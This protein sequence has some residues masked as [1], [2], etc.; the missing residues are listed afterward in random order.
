M[1]YNNG[2]MLGVG[3]GII[4]GLIISFFVLKAINKDGKVKTEYDEMQKLI[5]GK[6]YMYAFWAVIACEGLLCF[7]TSGSFSLP[8]D[9]YTLHF[10]VILVGV[11]VQVSYCIWNDAYIGLNNSMGRFAAVS[12]IISLVNFAFAGFSIA[13]GT[14]VKDGVL[15]STSINLLVAVL[16]IVIGLEIL[17]KKIADNGQKED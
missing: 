13:E 4:A 11:L 12:I 1:T 5:R 15:Q 6:A 17:I 16:F 8:L 2:K 10:M 7:L 3:I 9:G 14:M